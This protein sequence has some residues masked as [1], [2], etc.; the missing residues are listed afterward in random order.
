MYPTFGG[1]TL[2][3]A[4]FVYLQLQKIVCYNSHYI[5]YFSYLCF[6]K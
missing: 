1:E 4:E 6:V 2:F 3:I 5:I